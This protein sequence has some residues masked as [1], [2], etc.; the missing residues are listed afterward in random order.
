MFKTESGFIWRYMDLHGMSGNQLMSAS[1]PGCCEV[2]LDSMHGRS[3]SKHDWDIKSISSHIPSLYWNNVVPD[4][5]RSVSIC[6]EQNHEVYAADLTQKELQAH[7]LALPVALHPWREF[8]ICCP[9]G[10]EAWHRWLFV[11]IFPHQAGCFSDL[12][13]SPSCSVLVF[14]L[15]YNQATAEIMWLGVHSEFPSP[16]WLLAAHGKVISQGLCLRGG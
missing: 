13:A 2:C 5:G 6:L 8:I 7:W 3:R 1:G 4:A 11:W 12:K 15:L 14:F 9:V 10:N 16:F